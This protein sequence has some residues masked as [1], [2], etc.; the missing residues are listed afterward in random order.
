MKIYMDVDYIAGY[1]RGG[2]R[3]GEIDFSEEEERDFKQLLRKELNHEEITE[4]ELDRLECYKENIQEHS[5]I[6][7][8]DFRIEQ[9]GEP[10][11]EDLLD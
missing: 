1:L 8:D 4:A 11:W 3:E 9:C 6:E 10:I 7:V 2:H 5:W